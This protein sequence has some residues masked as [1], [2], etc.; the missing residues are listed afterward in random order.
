MADICPITIA[1]DTVL[2]NL[3][4][5]IKERGLIMR[6][7][8]LILCGILILPVVVLAKPVLVSNAE[9]AQLMQNKQIKFVNQK[10]VQSLFEAENAHIAPSKFVGFFA[11]EYKITDIGAGDV[12]KA[13]AGNIVTRIAAFQKAHPNYQVKVLEMIADQD[14]VFVHF[15]A[16]EKGKT[17][18]NS[19]TVF[20]L[21]NEKIVEVEQLSKSY[22]GN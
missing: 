8:K 22:A 14:K 4:R 5:I 15:I 6:F 10:A 2:L 21:K 1:N 11:K 13:M 3:V 16:T 19:F 12:P 7:I 9:C 18:L 17:I 20:T